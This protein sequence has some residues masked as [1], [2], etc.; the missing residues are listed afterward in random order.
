MMY[1]ISNSQ[2][3]F[4][5]SSAPSIGGVVAPENLCQFVYHANFGHFVSCHVGVHKNPK[6]SGAWNYT[7]RLGAWSKNEK[8]A[9]PLDWFPCQ[10]WSL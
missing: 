2:N 6:K 1:A 3:C 8:P 7:L 4:S 5:H 10:I 9:F